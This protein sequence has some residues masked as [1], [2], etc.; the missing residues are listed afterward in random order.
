MRTLLNAAQVY[1][2]RGWVT[3]P[4]TID[5]GGFPKKPFVEGWQ[6]TPLDWDAISSQPWDMAKGIGIVLGSRS[7]NLVAL[8]IDDEELADAVVNLFEVK[9]THTRLVRTAR[10]RLHCFITAEAHLESRRF[11]VLYHNREVTIE[12]KGT[13]TQVAAPPTP[14]YKAVDTSPPLPS[15]SPQAAWESIRHTLGLLP[16]AGE[17]GGNGNY[18]SPWQD[19]VKEGDRNDAI[20]I[21]SHRLREAG[22]P[23][24]MA[25]EIMEVRIEKG[26]EGFMPVHEVRQT[27]A[28]AYSKGV[29]EQGGTGWQWNT[30]KRKW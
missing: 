1:Y 2:E 19:K 3:T 9:Q 5:S 14:G 7:G 18:P 29:V 10:N 16:V 4:L 24:T 27:V 23:L 11:K 17:G 28:S 25:I 13:G 22:V 8:D 12:L 21:E 15:P 26:Y 30:R 20:Y 6:H